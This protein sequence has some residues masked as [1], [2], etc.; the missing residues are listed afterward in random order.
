MSGS[1]ST[2]RPP[3]R[4]GRGS[5]P[6]RAGERSAEPYD[7]RPTAS[8]ASGPSAALWPR[9]ALAICFC[10]MGATSPIVVAASPAAVE[11]RTIDGRTRHAVY[12]G[13]DTSGALRIVSGASTEHL[14]FD[15]LN[16]IKFRSPV[17]PPTTSPGAVRVHL[18]PHG[19]FTADILGEIDGGVR[20]QTSLAPAVEL[21]FEHLAALVFGDAAAPSDAQA[22]FEAELRN[23]LPGKDV[24]IALSGDQVKTA[25]GS[26]A[27]LGPSQGRF[28]FNERQRT[29]STSSAYGLVFAAGARPPAENLTTLHLAD[30]TVL[31]VRL[32][33]SDGAVVSAETTFGLRLDL[34]TDRVSSIAVASGRVAYLSDMMRQSEVGRTVE[35]LLHEPWRVRLD[36]SVAN[37]H[38]MLG[39]RRFEKGIGVHARAEL[40]FPLNGDFERLLATI[41]IDDAVRPRGNVVFRVLGDGK[42]LFDSGPVTGRDEPRD[43]AVEITGV[44]SLTLA[45][46]YGD[47]MDLSD[48]ANW[49]AARL[50]RPAD[51]QPST[52]PSP[53]A[54]RGTGGKAPQYGGEAGLRALDPALMP[55]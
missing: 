52:G 53:A 48:H 37:G 5:R 4:S 14:P 7:I 44:R 17:A 40:A 42:V 21:Q 38:I 55:G 36:R 31:P 15:E 51:S 35:G 47:Q 9:R 43:V 50:I 27:S 41:G 46:E 11:V 39:G 29:F 26:V 45:V 25:R 28:L 32:L 19:T 16:L 33:A 12:A 10:L 22:V 3:P 2:T 49:A 54:S 30:G 24:L 8:W 20:V 18:R 23:R 6:C 34:P 13:V 1:L